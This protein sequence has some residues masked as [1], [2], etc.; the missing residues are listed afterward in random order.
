MHYD[1]KILILK[2]QN[3]LIFSVFKIITYVF[4]AHLIFSKPVLWFNLNKNVSQ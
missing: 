1:F 2:P 3:Y 4:S